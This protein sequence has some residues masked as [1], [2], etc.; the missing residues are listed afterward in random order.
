[1]PA[2]RINSRVDG[3]IKRAAARYCNRL[4]ATTP[5]GAIRL[6]AVKSVSSAEPIAGAVSSR[7][8]EFV[9]TSEAAARLFDA[10]GG[11][12]VDPPFPALRKLQIVE[13]DGGKIAARYQVNAA[14]PF[15]E[16]TPGSGA[17]R[18]YAYQINRKE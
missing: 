8:F 18:L 5:R 13:K 14:R 2:N 7:E 17:L 12:R 16:L 11:S 4:E 15:V 3:A 9:L 6:D 1:M 10:L